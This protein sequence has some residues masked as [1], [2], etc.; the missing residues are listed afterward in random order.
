MS[1]TARPSRARSI[2]LGLAAMIVVVVIAGAIVWTQ[3]GKWGV[4]YFSFQDENGSQCTNEL[5]GHRCET[6]TLEHVETVSNF[7]WP[8]AKLVSGSYTQ[9]QDYDLEARLEVPKAEVK[10]VTKAVNKRY[11]KCIKNRPTSLPIEDLEKVCVRSNDGPRATGD[12]PSNQTYVVG[13]GLEEDGSMLIDVSIRS[14]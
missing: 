12:A 1:Q 8:A 5:L 2:L 13:T 9:S 4:P 11:G 3:A 14:R 6:I 10:K 7:D